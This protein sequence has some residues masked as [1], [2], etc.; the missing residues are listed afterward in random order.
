M[1]RELKRRA[2]R[3][4]R[5][6]AAESRSARR[7][8]RPLR[9]GIACASV[10]VMMISAILP[11][12][13]SSADGNMDG[14][15]L[16]EYEAMDSVEGFQVSSSTSTWNFDYNQKI[17][18]YDPQTFANNQKTE[19]VIYG[20]S[21]VLMKTIQFLDKAP[22]QTFW[23]VENDD[24]IEG[25]EKT[26]VLQLPTFKAYGYGGKV[27]GEFNCIIITMKA[28]SNL[29]YAPIT[30][31]EWGVYYQEND[32]RNRYVAYSNPSGV[33]P[34]WTTAWH[35]KLDL[36]GRYNDLVYGT[37]VYGYN[38]YLWLL[39]NTR[40]YTSGQNEAEDFTS[41]YLDNPFCRIMKMS[42]ETEI[43][44]NEIVRGTTAYNM[45]RWWQTGSAEAETNTLY[46]TLKGKNVVIPI[47]RVIR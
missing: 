42:L 47:R 6:S 14:T 17:V 12:F 36:I 41:E 1:N 9:V 38:D 3:S 10:A 25:A 40:L 43:L 2:S 21:T 27:V 7:R 15:Y 44:S 8:S 22:T 45:L 20:P 16:P 26:R 32:I 33:I 11:T 39:R 29:Q 31:L 37:S 4:E 5:A 19:S 30:K 13:A 24:Y 28:F 46:V 34:D 18:G 23:G 35:R